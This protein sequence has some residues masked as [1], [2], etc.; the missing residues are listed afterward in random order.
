MLETL[1][2]LSAFLVVNLDYRQLVP[3]VAVKSQHVY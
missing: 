3:K 1:Q 2:H